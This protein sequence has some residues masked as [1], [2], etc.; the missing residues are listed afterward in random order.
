MQASEASEG[1]V[2]DLDFHWL[3]IYDRK[4]GRAARARII[5]CLQR[6][7]RSTYL[8]CRLHSSSMRDFRASSFA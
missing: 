6:V 5:A 1:G 7:I 2:D 8:S 4:G 3:G